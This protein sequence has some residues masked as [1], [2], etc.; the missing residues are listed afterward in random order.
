MPLR[1]SG[2]EYIIAFDDTDEFGRS[3][4]IAE[5]ELPDGTYDGLAVLEAVHPISFLLESR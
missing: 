4:G 3:T 5:V 1:V 2:Q